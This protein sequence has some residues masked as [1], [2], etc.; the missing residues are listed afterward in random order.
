MG[1]T[2]QRLHRRG[3]LPST[4]LHTRCIKELPV[5]DSVAF[6]TLDGQISIDYADA[7]TGFGSPFAIQI[8]AEQLVDEPVRAQAVQEQPWG[9][10]GQDDH[11][12]ESGRGH[13]GT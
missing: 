2:E 13:R 6:A 12:G 1:A 8:Q 7:S 5:H 3:R 4:T 10:Q 9:R 11:I